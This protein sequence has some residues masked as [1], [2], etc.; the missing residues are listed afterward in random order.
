[1]APASADGKAGF[2]IQDFKF[3]EKSDKY[4]Y[5]C[6]CEYACG[7]VHDIPLIIL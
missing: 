1:M 2:H 3:G 4:L 5:F 7:L 6:F